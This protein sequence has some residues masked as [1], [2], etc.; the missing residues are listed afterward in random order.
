MKFSSAAVPESSS[1]LQNG[2]GSSG[3][4][5]ENFYAKTKDIDNIDDQILE[6]LRLSQL[7][8]DKADGRQVAST[9]N[10]DD[11][12]A[13]FALRK[14]LQGGDGLKSLDTDARFE[15]FSC[16]YPDCT[17]P[18][19]SRGCLMCFTAHIRDTEGE[20]ERSKGCVDSPTNVALYCSTAEYDG[21]HVHAVHGV[22]AQYVVLMPTVSAH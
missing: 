18:H 16:E 21:R 8:I 7:E 22:S 9:D 19:S 15:C 2:G 12:F 20:E 17:N 1:Y 13:D 5:Y 10:S 14:S 11:L 3:E 6:K 4:H